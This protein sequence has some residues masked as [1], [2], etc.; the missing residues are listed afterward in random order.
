[1][2]RFALDRHI[3][4]ENQKVRSSIPGPPCFKHSMQCH[5]QVYLA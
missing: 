1:M 4:S 2:T 5:A 3:A